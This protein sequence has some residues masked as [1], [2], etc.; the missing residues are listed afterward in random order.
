M[1]NAECRMQNADTDLAL[2]ITL[3]VLLRLV[4]VSAF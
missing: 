3:N 4:D 1:Q 2:R